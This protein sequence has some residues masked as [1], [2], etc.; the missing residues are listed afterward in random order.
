MTK[1]V[2]QSEPITAV[3]HAYSEGSSCL[4]LIDDI[5]VRPG[6][7]KFFRGSAV[8][9]APLIGSGSTDK[10][11][12]GDLMTFSNLESEVAEYTEHRKEHLNRYIHLKQCD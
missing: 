6:E 4:F 12:A 3:L 1:K 8:C 2:Y 11:F 5:M 9:Q 7:Q 10:C